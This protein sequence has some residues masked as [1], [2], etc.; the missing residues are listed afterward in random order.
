VFAAS[1]GTSSLILASPTTMVVTSI[2]AGLT[3]VVDGVNVTTPAT[4]TDWAPG[5]VHTVSAPTNAA[6]TAGSRLVFNTWSQGGA[7]SQSIVAPNSATTFT[8]TY[9]TQYE[10]TTTVSGNGTITPAPGWFDSGSVIA[11]AATPNANNIFLGFSGALSGTV[12]PQNLTMDSARNVIG[13]FAVGSPNLGVTVQSRVDGT[14]TNERVWTLNLTNSGTAVAPNAVITQ[15]QILVTN[16]TATVSLSPNT[17]LPVAAGSISAGNSAAVPIRLIFPVTVPASR[18][19][20]TLT[21]SPD[22]GLTTQ[23]IILNNQFR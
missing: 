3:L 13:S 20:L 4:Y 1:S 19:R 2:P 11:V 8:A 6:P 22:G 12:S 10:L 7:A 23:T 9:K 17:V 15:A 5:S 21:V 14:L 16:G 18:L